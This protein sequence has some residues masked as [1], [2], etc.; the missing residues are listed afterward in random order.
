[1]I[2]HSMHVYK[3]LIEEFTELIQLITKCE[4]VLVKNH[5]EGIWDEFQNLLDADKQE[6]VLK[7]AV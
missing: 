7:S 5:S 4:T 3:Y 2:F 6:G 1:M